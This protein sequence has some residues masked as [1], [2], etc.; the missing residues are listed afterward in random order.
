MGMIQHRALIVTAVLDEDI[1][2]LKDFISKFENQALFTFTK[3]ICNGYETLFVAPSGSKV[4]WSEY[5]DAIDIQDE[6][7]EFLEHQ[8]YDDGSSPYEYLQVDY[9]EFGQ[10]IITGNNENLY[11]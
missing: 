2:K 10:K 9:G 3:G 7:I 6:I 5:D 4:G 8:K 11:D 1:K